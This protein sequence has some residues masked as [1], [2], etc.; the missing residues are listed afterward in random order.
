MWTLILIIYEYI[1]NIGTLILKVPASPCNPTP[2]SNSP[3]WSRKDGSSPG[4]LHEVALIPSD[5]NFPLIFLPTDS[6]CS[7]LSP[8]LASAPNIYRK[9]VK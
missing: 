2:N 4:T 6:N 5:A 9:V 8:R 7:I 1:H 3:C